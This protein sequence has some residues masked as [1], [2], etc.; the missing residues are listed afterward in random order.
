MEMPGMRHPTARGGDLEAEA[1]ALLGGGGALDEPVP[2]WVP[3]VLERLAF[4]RS[5]PVQLMCTAVHATLLALVAYYSTWVAQAAGMAEGPCATRSALALILVCVASSMDWCSMIRT[6]RNAAL[7]SPWDARRLNRKA[8]YDSLSMY[9]AAIVGNFVFAT[10]PPVIWLRSALAEV[11]VLALA[12]TIMSLA[13]NAL[14]SLTFT[15]WAIYTDTWQR[16]FVRALTGGGLSYDSAVEEYR[17]L[18]ACRKTVAHALEEVITPFLLVYMLGQAV[19]LYDFEYRPWGGWPYLLWFVSQTVAVVFFMD[20]WIGLND[21]PE[22]L[23]AQVMESEELRW[24]P[25][26]RA[27]FVAHVGATRVK[28]HFFEFEMS[29]SFRTALPI[30]FFGWWLYATELR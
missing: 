28:V 19:L 20:P 1:E 8:A 25:G 17:R 15:F 12:V 10:L 30:F 6:I 21:W 5:L 2:E 27:N 29:K 11:A 26:E 7:P 3:P 23:C 4:I 24:T 13:H 22:E 9:P 18:N 14:N 16:E